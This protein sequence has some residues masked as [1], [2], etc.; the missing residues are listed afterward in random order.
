MT[1]ELTWQT[2]RDNLILEY[3]IPKYDGDLGQPTWFVPLSARSARRKTE[4]LLRHFA[5]QRSRSWFA[6]ETFYGLMRLRGI[7]C[8]SAS[9]FAEGFSVAS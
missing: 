6:A 8:R 1:G 3:E 2:W 7:E 9:G 4:H 5:S